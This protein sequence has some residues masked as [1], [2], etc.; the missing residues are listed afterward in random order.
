M[1]VLRAATA[2]GRELC[3]LGA[4]TVPQPGS[5]ADL[6]LLDTDPLDGLETLAAPRGVLAFGRFLVR[7][8]GRDPRR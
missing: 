6:I 8:D 2:G 3:G 4:E 5:A 7:P 1:T